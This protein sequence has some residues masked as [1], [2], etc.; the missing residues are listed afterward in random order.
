MFL[1]IASTRKLL[2]FYI[3]AP[4]LVPFLPFLLFF[5]EASLCSDIKVAKEMCKSMSNELK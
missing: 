5:S 3:F 2:I 1:S 4:L